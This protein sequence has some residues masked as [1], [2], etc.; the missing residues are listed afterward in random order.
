MRRNG[1]RGG[2]AG[3]IRDRRGAGRA[4][5]PARARSAAR[6]G[7]DH[8]PRRAELLVEIQRE[9]ETRAEARRD[10]ADGTIDRTDWLDIRQRTEDNITKARRKYDRLA[11]SATVMSDIP[12]SERV[13]NAWES[14][15]TDRKRAAI[16]A[17]LHRV[18]IKPLP[19]EQMP[20]S[21][22]TAR[23][24]PSAANA[25]WRSCGS[26]SN[27]TG[28]SNVVPLFAISFYSLDYRSPSV[29]CDL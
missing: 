13:R 1:D 17:M 5:V 23:T 9:Q 20:T 24:K 28:A 14:W 16:R 12:P 22:A 6:G 27:S 21:R 8:A 15:S 25:K 11:G 18:I 7:D 4:G 26:A 29:L 3:G 19:R 2:I 10:L